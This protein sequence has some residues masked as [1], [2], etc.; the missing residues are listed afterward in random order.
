MEQPFV[1]IISPMAL[2]ETTPPADPGFFKIGDTAVDSTGA[3][4]D[5]AGLDFHCVGRRAHAP[6]G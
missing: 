5:T 6:D 1:K 3:F 2:P 4:Q